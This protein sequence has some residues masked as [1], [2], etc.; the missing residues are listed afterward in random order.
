VHHQYCGQLGKPANCQEAVTLSIANHPGS[1]PIAHRLYLPKEW[2]D[3][4]ERR[5]KAH[6][7]PDI[8]FKTKQQIALEQ[9]RAAMPAGVFSRCGAWRF[10]LWRQHH[11]APRAGRRDC[12]Q[13]SPMP[14]LQAPHAAKTEMEF[15]SSPVAVMHAHAELDRGGDAK[16]WVTDR[17]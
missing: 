13:T 5:E 7:P 17:G 3:D 14:A 4:E 12:A 15:R 16:P 11:A 1:L 9:I 6:V 10:R 8:T 2:I